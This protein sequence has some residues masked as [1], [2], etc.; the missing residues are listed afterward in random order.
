[1]NSRTP[2]DKSVVHIEDWGTMNNCTNPYQAPELIK[3]VLT[4]KV[5]G[6]PE[7]KDGKRVITSPLIKSEGRSVET[8]HTHY[9]LG[10]IGKDYLNWLES[11]GIELDELN[12][13]KLKD[14]SKY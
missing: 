9:V 12:P 6:H 13:V 5:Y 14:P 10:E 1:M 3:I 2:E 11:Q 8:G 7:H 4:G